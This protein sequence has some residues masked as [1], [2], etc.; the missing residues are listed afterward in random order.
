[1]NLVGGT[2]IAFPA[3]QFAIWDRATYAK[4]LGFTL[5]NAISLILELVG[6]T[7]IAFPAKQFAIWDRA[8]Y[9]KVLG[10]TL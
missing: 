4:V 5:C 1:M 8:K 6:G 2:K 10:F 7:K 3:E 9:A